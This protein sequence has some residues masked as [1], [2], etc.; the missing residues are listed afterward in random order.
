MSISKGDLEDPKSIQADRPKMALEERLKADLRT[1]MKA[2]QS[3]TVATIRMML[4]AIDN[5][6]AVPLSASTGPTVGRSNDVPRR[7]LSERQK[8]ELLQAEAENR[9][10][11]IREYERLGRHK[12]A[13]QLRAEVAVFT[14]YLDESSVE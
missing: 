3:I 5:A 11:T 14:H 2:R 12:E 13:E 8:W 4:S 1:A 6:G 10:S 9:R 7:E